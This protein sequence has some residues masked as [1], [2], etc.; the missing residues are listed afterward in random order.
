MTSEADKGRRKKRLLQAISIGYPLAFACLYIGLSSGK[1]WSPWNLAGVIL[2][3]G[4]G[5]LTRAYIYLTRSK[6]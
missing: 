5:N 1:E 3:W 6:G 4:L 2:L